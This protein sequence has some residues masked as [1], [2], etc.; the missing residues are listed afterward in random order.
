MM[1]WTTSVPPTSPT[2]LGCPPHQPTSSSQVWGWG[3]SGE[4]AGVLGRQL[5]NTSVP[6][7]PLTSGK[8]PLSSMCPAIIVDHDHKVRMVVGASGGTQITTATALVCITHL[9]PP[10]PGP[11]PC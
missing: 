2:S 10:A 11:V 1:R 8:Q 7:C 3:L 6:N 4:G 9:H 5:T